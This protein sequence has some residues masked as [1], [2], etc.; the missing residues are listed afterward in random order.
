MMKSISIEG[1][2]ASGKSTLIEKIAQKYQTNVQIFPE[3]VERWTNFNGKNLLELLYGDPKKWSFSFQIFVLLTAFQNFTTENLCEYRIFER[4]LQS[5]RFC[6]AEILRNANV[7]DSTDFEIFCAWYEE[8]S[9]MSCTKI[10]YILYL[11]TNPEICFDR[12]QKRSRIEEEIVSLDY[13]NNLHNQ[14]ESWLEKSKN[15]VPVFVI[16]GNQ[17]AE[18]V[19]E[20]FESFFKQVFTL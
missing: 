20:S 18:N 16:D 3:P 6:F 5:C 19:F 14:H 10:D 12:M 9:K 2:I 1:N 13:L 17:S 4:S 8:L 15:N 7:L 11:R